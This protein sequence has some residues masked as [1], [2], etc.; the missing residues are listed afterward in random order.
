MIDH[1]RDSGSA[2]S[3]LIGRGLSNGAGT[4]TGKIE[5]IG[6]FDESGGQIVPF[7]GA[8]LPAGSTVCVSGWAADLHAQGAV[9]GVCVRLGETLVDAEYGS[10]RDDIGAEYGAPGFLRTGFKGFITVDRTLRGTFEVSAVAVGADARSSTVLPGGTAIVVVAGAP[11][12]AVQT[13]RKPGTTTVHVDAWYFQPGSEAS[14]D[15]ALLAP[16]GSLI[17]LRGWLRDE[18]AN[19]PAAAVFALVDDQDLV[20]GNAWQPRP[21]VVAALHGDALLGT[22][23]TVRVDTAALAIGW[24]SV[25]IGMMTADGTAHDIDER[26]FAFAVLPDH[27]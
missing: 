5:W 22:G 3:V 25:Q 13:P 23:F 7:G 2:L 4:V 19:A 14:I 8:P 1:G 21:D 6:R 24:H 16:R 26:R 12:V 10:W 9:A 27:R 18:T 11:A 17:T 20:R 15:D